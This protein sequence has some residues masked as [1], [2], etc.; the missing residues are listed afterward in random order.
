MFQSVT[1][2]VG[3]AFPKSAE[4]SGYVCEVTVEIKNL[5]FVITAKSFQKTE[6][7][8]I[9][10]RLREVTENQMKISEAFFGVLISNR[11]VREFLLPY[12][13]SELKILFKL[14]NNEL[15]SKGYKEIEK[16]EQVDSRFS[17]VFTDN[18]H[19]YFKYTP[20][21]EYTLFRLL[22]EIKESSLVYPIEKLRVGDKRVIFFSCTRDKNTN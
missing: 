17:L 2:W 14:L 13:N 15:K 6:V 22:Y 10:M 19:Y 3:F 20:H 8:H 12:D 7:H 11:N 21:F 9:R 4:E 1:S 5:F 16:L 18:K